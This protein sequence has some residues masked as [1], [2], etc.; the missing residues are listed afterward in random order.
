MNPHTIEQL[1]LDLMSRYGLISRGWIFAWDRAKRR[2]GL[3]C[4]RTQ[5]I[6]LSRPLALIAPEEVEDTLRH[7]IAH[8]LAG[9]QAGHGREWRII[10]RRVG[11]RPERCGGTHSKDLP[12]GWAATCSHCGYVSKF[13]RKPRRIKACGRCCKQYNGG[14]FTERFLLTYSYVKQAPTLADKLAHAEA[15]LMRLRQELAQQSRS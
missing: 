6:S 7:E 12:P 8:A 5:T 4:Y 3:C 11:A 13:F 1:A 2:Y 14:R 15:K 9:D 10:A